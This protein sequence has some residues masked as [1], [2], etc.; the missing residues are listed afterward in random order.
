MSGVGDD[1]SSPWEQLITWAGCIRRGG[2]L[3]LNVPTGGSG[4]RPPTQSRVWEY[5]SGLPII[6]INSTAMWSA[7]GA[8]PVIPNPLS[9]F[10]EMIPYEAIP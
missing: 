8:I 3:G 6:D 10:A 1:P 7:F 2:L 4:R 5:L 9:G